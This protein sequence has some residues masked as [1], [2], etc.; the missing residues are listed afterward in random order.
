[1]LREFKILANVTSGQLIHAGF[2]GVVPELASRAHQRSIVP[3]VEQALNEAGLSPNELDAIAYTQGP[4]LLGSLLV[5]ASFAKSMAM[6][7]NIP[8]I[9][10][11]HMKAHVLAHFIEEEGMQ[12]PPFPFLCLTVSGGHTQLLRVEG[13]DRF[14]VLGETND[15][16]AGEAF[17]KAAKVL[18]LPY[19]GGPLIDRH[20]AQGDPH[21]FQFT[22]PRVPGL[23]FSFSGL[24]TAFRL[25]VEKGVAN[26]P[27]FIEENLPHLC[28][29]IQRT[30]VEML[31][32]N[33]ER[34]A[35][36]E[37]LHHVALAGGVSAN[38]G[39]REGL[40]ALAAERD[41]TTYIPPLGYCTD[42]GAM[43]AIAGRM[44][45]DAG[46]R[47][48]LSDAARARWAM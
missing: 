9:P 6:A 4:G 16:A 14:V 44:L 21:R 27:H 18:G 15:D 11:H 24:K 19:P 31:L 30:I 2:G 32:T 48:N 36:Q 22:K 35:M 12:A 25:L 7:L 8:A 45:L 34:A 29:S 46:H 40:Q 42:N 41:W 39:L 33:L 26:S 43:I 13:A 28:A 38:R 23:D 3:V 5:G 20:A 1:V 10:V 17:D 47:G 37:G